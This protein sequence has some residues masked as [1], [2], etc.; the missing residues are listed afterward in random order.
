MYTSGKSYAERIHPWVGLRIPDMLDRSAANWPDSPALL[1]GA[2]V[3]TFLELRTAVDDAARNLVSSGINEGDHVATY[4]GEHW[5]HVVLVYAIMQIGAVPVPLNITWES[6]EIISALRDAEVKMLLAQRTHRS[7][8]ISERLAVF[9]DPATPYAPRAE[10]PFL[11]SVRWLD[12]NGLD[13]CAIDSLFEPASGPVATSNNQVAYL[14]FTSGTSARAK[15]VVL[16]HQA[17]LGVG[18]LTGARSGYQPG[19]RFLN[20]SPL[21]HCGG[22]ILGLLASHQYGLAVRLIEGYQQERILDAMAQ[23]SPVSIVGF[24]IVI[25]RL[26]DAA[27]HRG[28]G[29]PFRTVLSAP[30]VSIFDE[31]EAEGLEVVIV[32]GSTEFTNVAAISRGDDRVSRRR[33]GN[34]FPLPRVDIRVCDPES[35]IALHAG[36]PGE[37]RGRGWN[38]MLGY[39]RGDGAVELP[40][41]ADGFFASG[42][43][44][45]LDEDGCVYYRGRYSAMVKTGGENVS[46]TEVENVLMQIDGISQAAVIGVADAQWGEMVVAFVQFE[47]GTNEL[48]SDELRERCR[49]LMAGYKI[50]K[51]F[52]TMNARDWPVTPTGKVIKPRLLALASGKEDG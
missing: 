4:L 21:Y 31:L 52:I 49:G 10:L 24:D 18:Y 50:P 47:E 12:P 9:G 40:L 29:L 8:D 48:T 26:L 13:E 41:D 22:Q 23:D 51:R 32:Y 37:I 17:A 43:Y 19:E 42:D 28:I 38:L 27:R 33:D 14:M 2:R 5:Q 36:E 20:I 15:A 46:Q 45:F 30:G 34:G 11:S 7:T 3:I 44:G 16:E 25:R 35:G 1:D 6:A 39:Y